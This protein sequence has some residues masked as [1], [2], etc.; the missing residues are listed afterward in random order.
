MLTFSAGVRLLFV[1]QIARFIKRYPATNIIILVFL[2]LIGITLS[3]QGLGLVVPERLFNSL[4]LI[5]LFAA[6]IYQIR[7]TRSAQAS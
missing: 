2:I 4:L 1:Q 5:A 3:A 6:L 7:F